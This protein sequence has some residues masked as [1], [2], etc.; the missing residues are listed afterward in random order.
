MDKANMPSVAVK[1]WQS[2]GKVAAKSW[3][4]CGK[5]AATMRQMRSKRHGKNA[6]KLQQTYL[7]IPGTSSPLDCNHIS[8]HSFILTHLG[9]LSFS[10]AW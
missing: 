10:A 7:D 3:Q 4:S 8:F 6:S 1:S 2:R 9:V 5:R